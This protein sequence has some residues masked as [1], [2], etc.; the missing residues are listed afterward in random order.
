M[1]F[2]DKLL[3]ITLIL[4]LVVNQRSLTIYGSSFFDIP[5]WNENGTTEVSASLNTDTFLNIESESAILIEE[6]TGEILFEK[7]SHQKL[8]PASI[9]KIMTILL[10]MENLKENNITLNDKVPCS[11]NAS[12]MGGSQIWLSTNETLTVEEMLKA[13]CVVSANDCA[14]AMAEYISGSEEAF[15]ILMN[16]KAKK[17]GMNDTT[18]KNCHGID[19][20]GHLSSSYD[21]SIMSRE[22]LKNHPE[23]KKYTGIWMDSL[24]NGSSQLVNTNKLIRTYEGATGL[25]TGSTSLAL[26]NLSASATR[27]NLSL[28]SVV[29]KAPTTELRFKE[30]KLLLDY[31]FNKYTYKNLAEKDSICETVDVYKGTENKTD[32]VFESSSGAIIEK[33]NTKNI[34][35]I[36]SI[37]E[38]ITA[39]IY[40][41]EV[42][43]N[44]EYLI[45]GKTISKVNLVA[46]KDI[47]KKTFSNFFKEINKK[48]FK[49]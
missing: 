31:G 12:S 13:I 25:K 40:K 37:K 16:E 8:H 11:E 35:T 27:D 46:S 38:N 30:A 26:Y 45:D 39:P 7:N 47:Q 49:L 10:I 28:I 42:L 5:V 43:G 32:L 21:I 14:V 9:T 24:R 20:E 23:I 19:E 15:V 33:N 48:Y 18:F 34:E 36:I 44:I 29:L 41:N 1:K 4:F 2:K 22:L 6:N 17:L 3:T